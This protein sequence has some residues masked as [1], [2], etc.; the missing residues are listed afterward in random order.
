[1]PIKAPTKASTQEHPPTLLAALSADLAEQKRLREEQERLK[2]QMDERGQQAGQGWIDT[3]TYRYDEQK[4]ADEGRLT[5]KQEQVIEA[6]D[7]QVREKEAA[8][9]KQ[10]PQT[11]SGEQQR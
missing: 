6:Q 1:M 9:A 8:H 4:A 5:P 11:G 7:R 2:I 10:T 3:H